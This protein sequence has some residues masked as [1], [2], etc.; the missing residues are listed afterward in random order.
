MDAARLALRQPG[1]SAV[2]LLYRRTRHEMPAYPEEIA[3]AIDEGVGLETL[4]TPVAIETRSGAVTGIQLLRNSLG[5]ADSSGRR[6]P[7]PIPGS[8][9]GIPLD[10]LIVAISEAPEV[11]AAAG[12]QTSRG[13]LQV[14]ETSLVTSLPGVFAGG[15]VIRGPSTVI[16]AVADGKRAAR[17]IEN[18]L[19]GK[20]LHAPRTVKL[21][22]VFVEPVF[23]EP[24]SA[25]LEEEERMPRVKEP[26]LPPTLRARSFAEVQLCISEAAARQEARRCLRCDL[27][28][29][30]PA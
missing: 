18:Y 4:V 11:E 29:T 7:V 14:D 21:P 26:E 3:M 1:V 8:D 16:A 28:F 12:L 19:C 2:T 9:F 20:S 5:D 27:V 15:D 25:Q 6:R 13:L 23:V 17:M 24:G 22:T 30:R 10:T